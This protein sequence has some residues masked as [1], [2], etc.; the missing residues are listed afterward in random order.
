MGLEVSTGRNKDRW[1]CSV[2]VRAYREE[3]TA[4]KKARRKKPRTTPHS[5]KG[6][7]AAQSERA[8]GE[9]DGAKR[10]DEGPRVAR[11]KNE[12]IAGD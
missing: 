4:R 5:T 1:R 2:V 7:R 6:G 9:R 3:G 11:K 12:I 8:A 10:A